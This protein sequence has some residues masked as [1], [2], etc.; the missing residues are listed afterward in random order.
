MPPA[1]AIQLGWPVIYD[2]RERYVTG[3]DRARA[4]VVID[5]DGQWRS[6]AG[7]DWVRDVYRSQSGE[8]ATKVRLW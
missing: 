6:V 8:P 3:V 7:L 4:L 1:N 2:G 5:G